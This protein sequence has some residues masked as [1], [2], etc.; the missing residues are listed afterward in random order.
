[1]CR[2]AKLLVSEIEFHFR[3]H[4]RLGEMFF[5]HRD[6]AAI[7]GRHGVPVYHISEIFGAIDLPID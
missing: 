3:V 5:L 7:V 2:P 4:E 6:Q 1:M